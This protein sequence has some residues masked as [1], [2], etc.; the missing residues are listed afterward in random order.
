MDA[1]SHAQRRTTATNALLCLALLWLAG[2]G[3]RITILAVPPVNSDI[4]D[5]LGMTATQVGI[6]SGLPMVLFAAAAVPGSLLI[7][8]FGA[9]TDLIVGLLVTSLGSAL[10]GA[11]DTIA[12]LYAAT[13]LTGLGVAVIQPA[14][15][16]L[17]RAWV[18]HRIGFATAVYTNGLLI[19]EVIPI[20]LTIPLV[21][22][23]VGGSWRAS[24]VVW[25]IPVAIIAMIVALL[26]P[27][28][29]RRF[30]FSTTTPRRY[31][32]V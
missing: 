6:L 21:L 30:L 25:S 31:R 10:R 15:P 9:L 22:P 32:A 4:H 5:D 14:M 8:R 19:G 29:R 18:P 2:N 24:F 1:T 3:M 26:A 23:M 27:R 17:V 7:A 20:A 16:P 13:V 11:S 28:N 12:L